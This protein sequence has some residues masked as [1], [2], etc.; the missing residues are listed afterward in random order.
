MAVGGSLDRKTRIASVI[1]LQG[2]NHDYE[3]TSADPLIKTFKARRNPNGR[4]QIDVDQDSP[5]SKHNPYLIQ[6]TN[7]EK[8]NNLSCNDLAKFEQDQM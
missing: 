4:K 7:L 6:T 5:N 3:R 1:G 8:R 2:L